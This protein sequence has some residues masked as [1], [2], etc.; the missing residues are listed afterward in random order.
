LKTGLLKI[1]AAP[2]NAQQYE[3]KGVAHGAAASISL[4]CPR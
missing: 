1:L 2:K 3:I 4:F